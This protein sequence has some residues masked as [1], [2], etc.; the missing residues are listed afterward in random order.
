MRKSKGPR[1]Q[2]F[3]GSKRTSLT[4]RSLD[5]SNFLAEAKQL[6]RLR[7]VTTE[8]NRRIARYVGR[9]LREEG[10]EVYYQR[11]KREGILFYNVIGMKGKGKDPLIFMTHL[12]TV[13]AGPSAL[14]TETG[15]DPWKPSLQGRR[16]YG[17]GSADTK[18]DILAKIFAA[19]EIPPSSMKR[20]LWIVGTFGEE[21][22][23]LGARTFCRRVK[24]LRG[25]AYVSEPTGLS[26]VHEHRGYLVL[27]V[28]F[29]RRGSFRVRRDEQTF[30]LEAIG[31]SAHSSTP[32]KGKNAIRLAF[33]FLQR[34]AQKDPRLQLLHA[35]GGSSPNQVP[36]SSRL[37]FA[38]TLRHFPSHPSIQVHSLRRIPS[39]G[40]IPWKALIDLFEAI[41]VAIQKRRRPMTSNV[42]VIQA[43]GPFLRFLVDFRVHPKE[44]NREILNT[45]Q[46]LMQKTLRRHGLSPSFRIE[47]DG[48]P[49]SISPK[50]PIVR[51]ARRVSRRAGLPFRLEKK[52]S[53]T[54]AG[55]LWER[56]IP[57]VVF[58][59]GRSL[60]NIHAPNE[61]NDLG[62][63]EK[64]MA[65][66]HTLIRHYCVGE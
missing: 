59:P 53:C 37:V 47:R 19:R 3:K 42:G 35:E 23:L 1:V 28:T 61:Y 18:L 7:S 20:P 60:G 14:W 30:A 66:Y 17:L 63:L 11:E 50:S 40:P 49:L 34:L 32:Q 43:K 25:Y 65:L 24:G 26:W 4:P 27:E 31:K 12:D 46:R 64:A 56:G 52:P 44:G 9:L 45:F 36:S 2:G 48:P 38:T 22:G 6:I 29:P 5:P 8:T 62:Q 13:P 10:F 58:G 21:R 15:T 39:G 33:A 57:A 41:D 55:L 16:I 51:M 54:E